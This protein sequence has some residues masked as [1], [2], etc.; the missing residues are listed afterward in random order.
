MGKG[1]DLVGLVKKDV[2][3]DLSEFR[4]R[5]IVE[6][7]LLGLIHGVYRILTQGDDETTLDDGASRQLLVEFLSYALVI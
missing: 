3:C 1:L 5:H 7:L 6:L 4:K 2:V